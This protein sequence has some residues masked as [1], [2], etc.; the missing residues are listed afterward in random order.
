MN[1]VEKWIAKAEEFSVKNKL[2]PFNKQSKDFLDCSD[3]LSPLNREQMINESYKSDPGADQ[4]DCRAT[5]PSNMKRWINFG[6]YPHPEFGNKCFGIKMYCDP[7]QGK[8]KEGFWYILTGFY[9]K[10]EEITT[11]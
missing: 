1:I 5:D 11:Q 8:D 9:F 7:I 4:F 6:S 3:D 10:N 2:N